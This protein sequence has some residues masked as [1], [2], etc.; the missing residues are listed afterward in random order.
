MDTLSHHSSGLNSRTGSV[1]DEY[2]NGPILKESVESEREGVAK[3]APLF[4]LR[5]GMAV[6]NLHS[7]SNH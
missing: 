3:V 5:R 6:S 4:A 7:L 1:S 2:P